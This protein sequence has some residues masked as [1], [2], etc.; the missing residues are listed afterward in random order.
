MPKVRLAAASEIPEGGMTMREHDGRQILLAKID[1]T[2]YAMNDVCTHRGAPLHT[3][4]LGQVGIP[5]LLTCPLHAAHF[6]V[7]TGKVYQETPW[8]TDTET[9]PVEVE[10]DDVYV[11]LEGQP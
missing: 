4:E 8:A 11:E 2:I 1:G 9:Y 5:Q 3:G 10:G 6:D 7:T